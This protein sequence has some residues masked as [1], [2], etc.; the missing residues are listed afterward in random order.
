MSEEHLIQIWCLYQFYK[1][2]YD[3]KTD[4]LSFLE[5]YDV[6]QYM[7]IAFCSAES[8]FLRSQLSALSQ[9]MLCLL[10]NCFLDL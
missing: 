2:S 1:E 6:L 9:C 10:L 5:I 8:S 7:L 4:S 3:Q